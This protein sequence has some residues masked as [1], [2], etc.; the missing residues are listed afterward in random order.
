DSI[1]KVLASNPTF[2]TETDVYNKVCFEKDIVIFNKVKLPFDKFKS[3]LP[4]GK[5]LYY[6]R[7]ATKHLEDNKL[8]I[9]NKTLE[10]TYQYIITFE[11]L[12]LSKSGGL[13]RKNFNANVKSYLQNAVWG[14]TLVTFSYTT[15]SFLMNWNDSR[16]NTQSLKEVIQLNGEQ[17]KEV[18]YLKSELQQIKLLVNEN[19]K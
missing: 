10:E 8:L 12:L 4:K 7:L 18:K 14:V 13:R 11:G 15:F 9:S 2:N 19:Q 1:L 17:I 5:E 3:F 6:F 16:H